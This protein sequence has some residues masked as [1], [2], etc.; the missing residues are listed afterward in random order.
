MTK[1]S[2]GPEHLAWISLIL[3]LVL[4]GLTFFIGRWSGYTAVSAVAW[5]I[6][7]SALI[8]FVLAVQFHLRSLAEQEKLDLMQLGRDGKGTTLFQGGAERAALMAVAQK[9]HLPQPGRLQ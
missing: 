4:F 2:K 7:S 1:S 5:Q 3:G 8:W 9:R 6:L